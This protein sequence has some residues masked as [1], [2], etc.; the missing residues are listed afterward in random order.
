MTHRYFNK[1]R[2][3]IILLF[4]NISLISAAHDSPVMG[5]GLDTLA[6]GSYRHLVTCPLAPDSADVALHGKKLF[7]EQGQR[8]SDSISGFGHLTAMC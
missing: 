6:A 4:C 7:G 5:N 2:L 3:L 8:L 1:V